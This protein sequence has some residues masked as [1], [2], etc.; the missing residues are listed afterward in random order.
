MRELR[1]KGDLSNISK[2]E[3]SSNE[4]SYLKA[5]NPALGA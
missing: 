3:T 4:I 5:E 1:L 2:V